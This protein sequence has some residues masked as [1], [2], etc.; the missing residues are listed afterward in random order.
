MQVQCSR[1]L[2]DHS[3][4]IPKSYH[5]LLRT[6]RDINTRNNND[7]STINSNNGNQSNH[8]NN[9]SNASNSNSNNSNFIVHE[10][11]IASQWWGEER[12]LKRGLQF[13]HAIGEV[14]VFKG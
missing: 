13:L 4:K 6:I 8:N 7:A 10:E 3:K 9:N 11:V 14:V 12:V 5:N 2:D 1:I